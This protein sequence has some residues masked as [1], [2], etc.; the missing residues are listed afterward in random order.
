M[1][2]QRPRGGR[3]RRALQTPPRRVPFF[4]GRGTA[5]C[6]PDARIFYTSRVRAAAAFWSHMGASRQVQSWIKRGTK[7]DWLHGPPAPFRR[8]PHLVRDDH[9]DFV[10][11]KIQ[12]GVS[13]GAHGCIPQGQANWLAKAHVVESA[14]KLRLV[15]DHHDLN[16]A[17]KAATCRYESVEDLVTLVTPR[18]WLFSCDL[19]AAYH[20]CKV[21]NAH[22]KYTGFH[23]ALPARKADGTVVPLQ[24]GGY[25]VYAH[26]LQQPDRIRVRQLLDSN[27]SCALP[28]ARMPSARS[29]AQPAASARMPQAHSAAQPAARMP[30]AHSA[31][32]PAASACM[33]PAHSAAQ[34][35]ARMPPAY[36]AAQPAASTRM[37]AVRM[38][39]RA[40]PLSD[41]LSDAG[42][43]TS[44]SAASLPA[45]HSAARP[46]ATSRTAP[47]AAPSSSAPC[48][49][50]SSSDSL[51][52]AQPAARTR[53]TRAPL[54]SVAQP[55]ARTHSPR[56][57]SDQQPEPLYQV[58][59][60]CAF[61]LNFGARASPLVFTKHMRSLV[62]YLRQHAI[63]VVIY[64]DD[65]AFVVE[66]S[67]AAAQRARDFV[68]RTLTRAG[69]LRHP[70]KGQFDDPSQVLHDHLG[71][72]LNIP[73]NVLRVPERRC[74]K[75]R[76]LAV[77]LRCEAARNRRLV[78]TR[79]LQQFTGT[80]CSTSRAVRNARFHL[81]SLYDCTSLHRP[82]SRLS[83]TAL[84][85][86]ATWAD[87]QFDSPLNGVPI[88]VSP[89]S[90]A[91]YTDAS[92]G[93][94]WG[95]VLPT[96]AVQQ[97]LCEA[98]TRQPT[99]SA[100]ELHRLAGVPL[101]ANL[102]QRSAT[103]SGSWDADLLPLHINF[104]ELRAVH[105]SLQAWR[106]DL[107]GHRVLLF[108]DNTAVVQL[109]RKGTSRSALLMA[110]LRQVWQLLHDM[111][112]ELVPVYIASGDNPADFPSRYSM[113]AEWTFRPGMRAQLHRLSQRAYSLDPF[114]TRATAMAPTFCSLQA[115]EHTIANDGMCVSWKRQH[116][117][118]NP[119][120]DLIPKVLLKI[121]ADRASGVLIV[122][123]WPSQ[124][125]W[126]L[127][128]R[129]RAQWVH[130]P[131][132]RHC[133]LPLTRHRVDPFAHGTTRLMALV[134][135]ASKGWKRGTPAWRTRSSAA[136]LT[137]FRG[138]TTR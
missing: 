7:F 49:G 114:A 68:E 131:A 15:V 8:A 36:S 82:L 106:A 6:A 14:N 19:V 88:F 25:F 97:Q 16:V 62:K 92:G 60:L 121:V 37:P 43:G 89:T 75:I 56:V 95:G 48:L 38:P 120:W 70:S 133:V 32:Q 116:L 64:L 76:K 135:D 137:T 5:L 13:T 122:P 123:R 58:V 2:P 132:P 118:L 65:L 119:P 28:A 110:E 74:A 3:Q 124:A 130:L 46:A 98:F 57:P 24:Q 134:F 113:S 84:Q 33:S 99:A 9:V 94:G 138:G 44:Y 100:E 35:A 34:P 53:S 85:D 108:C 63:G 55:A 61:A 66:G 21:A 111:Q 78:G 11:D 91:L 71:Y 41:Q 83:R 52:T 67:R 81:R 79:L 105:R 93:V 87:F 103:C 22:R 39:Q 27:I 80:A 125:W 31:A 96:T 127:L 69:L 117:F 17:C 104:K 107:Q 136:C 73:L 20:H 101:P 115:E 86:L 4:P 30:P 26:D 23:L 42:G 18:S 128:L 109:L 29:A 90:R 50:S 59:E 112:V 126:P 45:A 72:E 12:E 51:S 54:S 102:W 10:L 77:A 129:L 47:P 1:R 40:P